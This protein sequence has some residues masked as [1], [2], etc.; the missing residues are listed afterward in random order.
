MTKQSKNTIIGSI[1]LLIV[2]GIPLAIFF[3]PIAVSVFAG[4]MGGLVALQFMKKKTPPK[5]TEQQRQDDELI[6]VVLPT[7]SGK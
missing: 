3:A 2:I 7:I 1:F 4:Y 5:R 6:T